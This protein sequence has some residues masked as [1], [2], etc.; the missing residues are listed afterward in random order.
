MKK[1]T[2]SIR[3][4]LLLIV[5][6]LNILI[7]V[8]VGNGVYES[9][10]NYKQAQRLKLGASVIDALY[11]ATKSW[12]LERASSLSILHAPPESTESMHQDLLKNRLEADKALE[13]A[14][15]NLATSNFS[16]AINTETINE[17][18]QQLLQQRTAID[19][20]LTLPIA[21]RDPLIARQYF[22]L[23]T[24]LITAT[25]NFILVYSRTYQRIDATIGQQMTFKYFVWELAEHSGE[26]YAIIGQ[27]IAENKKPTPEQQKKLVSLRGNIEYGWEI[28]R[29]FA[30]NNEL[31]EQLLPLMEEAYTHY[32]FT[33]DQI[34]D[35]FYSGSSLSADTAYPISAE[36]W[37]GMSAQA[38]ESL[39]LLQDKILTETQLRV[40]RIEDKAKQEI[41]LSTIIFLFALILSLYCWS[42]I[43]FRIAR[44]VN[45]MVN[46]LYTATKDNTFEA[47]KIRHHNDEI[48]KLA[49]VL[50]VFQS[51]THKIQ[52]SN[53]ALERF[54]YIAAHDL[55]TPL[56]AVDTISQ[57]LE[58]DLEDLLP[59]KSK[60]HLDELRRRVKFMDKLLDDTLEYARIDATMESKPTEIISGQQLIDEI[61]TLLN[62][63]AGF[64]INIAEQL[65]Q[66]NLKKFPLQQI[67][68]NLINN[69]IKHHD[70]ECGTVDI[71]IEENASGYI[72]SVRDDGPGI[73]PRYHHKIFEMF[74]T[75]QPR[76]KSKGRGMGLAI[77]RKIIATTGGAITIESDIG[78]GAIFRF[79][80]P[81]LEPENTGDACANARRRYA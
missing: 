1:P 54:A 2:P 21:Q 36:M 29:K 39:L 28:L 19:Q 16:A 15:T 67:L 4:I 55:K 13:L 32:F 48:G 62:P 6:A 49:K 42:I 5:G 30:K 38:V 61:T 17:H 77:V 40:D 35:L 73:D 78:K 58:E 50:E 65:A 80:W 9:W 7:A 11:G 25:Q 47:P 52:Q 22:D 44:P 18:Y 79:T 14:L 37:L 46:A 27:M 26:E 45:A 31:A 56:R 57:W 10:E 34:N 64:N 68:Y 43:V 23:S 63:P 70:K 8:L 24:A 41:M 12:S 60:Q 59:E 71:H 81:K 74:Q 51:N 66:I 33:F 75:L 53:E 76:D 20:A 3:T 69:A 72:F